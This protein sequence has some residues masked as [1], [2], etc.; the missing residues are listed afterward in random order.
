MSRGN[1]ELVL[2]LYDAVQRGDYESPFAALD[3]DILWDMSAFDLPDMARVYRGHAGVREF[4]SAGLL[5]GRRSNSRRLLPRS[6]GT[7][8]S[9]K[10]S[11]ATGVVRAASVSTSSTSKPSSSV[12]KR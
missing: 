7:M 4:G 6:T 12:E 8:S 5:P 1:V 9:S 11:N 2:S 3:E 10:S